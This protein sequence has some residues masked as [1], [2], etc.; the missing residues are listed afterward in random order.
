MS[1]LN[2]KPGTQVNSA[3]PD[4]NAASDQCLYCLPTELD[5]PLQAFIPVLT[6]NVRAVKT[7]TRRRV[8]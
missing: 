1:L 6:L 3:D 2:Y 4:Q 8:C 7:L 5:V